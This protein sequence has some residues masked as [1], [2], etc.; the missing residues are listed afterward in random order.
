MIQLHGITKSFGPLQVLRGID[1]QVNRGEV[2][3]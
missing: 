3:A 2:M 1:L